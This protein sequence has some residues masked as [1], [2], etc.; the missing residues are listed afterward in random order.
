MAVS[1][2]G[3]PVLD[4]GSKYLYTWTLAT[5]QGPVRITLRNGSAGFLLCHFILWYASTIEPVFDPKLL[6]DWGHAVRPVRGR[7]SGFSNHASGTAAD[8]NATRHPIGRAGTLGFKVRG[9]W[10][11][12]RIRTRLLMYRGCIRAGAFY[13]GR[14]DEM[15]YEI[16]KSLPM[17]EKAARRLLNSPR[18]RMILALNPEQKAVILS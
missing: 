16:N 9:V 12:T 4:P 13:H 17:V 18:G 6:D 11:L 3:W 1:M 8:V 7:T 2:N 10:A 5:K 15:H 14:K